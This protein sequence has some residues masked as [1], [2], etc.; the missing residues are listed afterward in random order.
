MVGDVL[1]G[2]VGFLS[3]QLGLAADYLHAVEVVTGDDRGRARSVVATRETA[4][5]NRELWWAHTGGGGGNF[6]IVT[7]YWFRLPNETNGDPAKLLPPAPDSITTFDAAWSWSDIDRQTFQRLLRNHGSWSE[8]NS[9][10][11]SP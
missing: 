3:R 5:P 1:G 4:D 7:R 6:G 8:R 2:A 10:P 9:S 11:D